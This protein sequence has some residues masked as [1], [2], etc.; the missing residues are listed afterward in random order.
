MK[1]VYTAVIKKED[2]WWIGWIEEV[3]GVNGQEHTREE[4]IKSLKIALQEALEFNSK[5]KA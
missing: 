1:N 2:D 4:L 3:S 5:A